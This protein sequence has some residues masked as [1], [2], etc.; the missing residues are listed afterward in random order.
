MVGILANSSVF[1]YNQ[2]F[3]LAAYVLISI[4]KT[5][6]CPGLYDFGSHMN[7]QSLCSVLMDLGLTQ[8]PGSASVPEEIDVWEGVQLLVCELKLEWMLS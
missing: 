3:L 7:W 6:S 5:F 2:R 1:W 8:S 4:W